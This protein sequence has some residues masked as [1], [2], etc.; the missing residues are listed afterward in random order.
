MVETNRQHFFSIRAVGGPL[1]YHQPHAAREIAI[2]WSDL[3]A[4]ARWQLEALSAK[5]FNPAVEGVEFFDPAAVGAGRLGLSKLPLSVS[6]S[7][8]DTRI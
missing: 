5:E 2:A 6:T 8:A 1:R 7:C 4:V 3:D